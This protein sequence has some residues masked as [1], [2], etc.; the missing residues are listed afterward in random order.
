MAGSEIHSEESVREQGL[1]ESE[2]QLRGHSY[3]KPD[4]IHEGGQK[5]NIVLEFTRRLH[6]RLNM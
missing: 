5:R 6:L 3:P 2:K 1:K 4:G